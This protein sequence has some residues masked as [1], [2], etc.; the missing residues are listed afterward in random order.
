MNQPEI[1]VVLIGDSSVG[2]TC[3]FRRLE[4]KTDDLRQAPTIGEAFLS[5]FRL[6]FRASPHSCQIL[7]HHFTS[8]LSDS[9]A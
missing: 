3:I 6:I 7:P 4:S 1:K 9:S 8:F 5:V 2:K